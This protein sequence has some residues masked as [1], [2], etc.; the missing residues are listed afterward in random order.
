MNTT[1]DF[2]NL[3]PGRKFAFSTVADPSKVVVA[4]Y[5]G[6]GASN[7]SF[8]V[9]D[10]GGNKKEFVKTDVTIVPVDTK[11]DLSV[12]SV[13]KKTEIALAIVS[14]ALANGTAR[15]DTIAVLVEKLGMSKA[16][17]ST[18]F[19]NAKKALKP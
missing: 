10:A 3:R 17:A 14:E 11:T 16:G 15:K 19:Y 7:G 2:K 1:T 5:A 4:N 6:R 9:E 18:Y 12:F 13:P 8:L